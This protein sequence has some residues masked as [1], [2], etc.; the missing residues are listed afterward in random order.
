V[1]W[2]ERL[3]GRGVP[4]LREPSNP[5]RERWTIG[6]TDAVPLKPFPREKFA[7]SPNRVGFQKEE[8]LAVERAV[9]FSK[10][11]RVQE[12]KRPADPA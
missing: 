4:A 5:S 6:T 11:R 7:L 3:I 9:S 10:R 12:E 1:N 2:H 8:L